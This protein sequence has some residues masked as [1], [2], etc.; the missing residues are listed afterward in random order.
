MKVLIQLF[1]K[2][3]GIKGVKPLVELASSKYPMLMKKFLFLL[4]CIYLLM[5][6]SLK[7]KKKSFK[8]KPHKKAAAFQGIKSLLRQPVFLFV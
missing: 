7:E 1:Q 3:V 8:V 5:R 2:L 6:S 4:L